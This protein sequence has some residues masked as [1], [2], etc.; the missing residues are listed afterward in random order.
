MLSPHD[1]FPMHP[2]RNQEPR[3]KYACHVCH[4]HTE[5]SEATCL[6]SLLRNFCLHLKKDKKMQSIKKEQDSLWIL[7]LCYQGEDPKDTDLTQLVILPR[8]NWTSS[9]SHLS[10]SMGNLAKGRNLKNGAAA[11]W[12]LFCCFIKNITSKI[13]VIPDSPIWWHSCHN[14]WNIALESAAQY[15]RLADMQREL[16]NGPV[17]V[18]E[19]SQVIKIIKLGKASGPNSLLGVYYNG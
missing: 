12:H 15:L 17:R 14:S 4:R 3:E 5:K 16:M 10:T 2:P 8:S 7:C 19:T 1:H 13:A 11:L 6:P 18:M 9:Y